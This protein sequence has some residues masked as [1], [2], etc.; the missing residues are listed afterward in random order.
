VERAPDPDE[1]LPSPA[2]APEPPPAPAVARVAAA[3]KGLG[4]RQGRSPG[5]R[6]P[7]SRSILG[8]FN[9]FLAGGL[10]LPIQ[11]LTLGLIGG[12]V[13]VHF[14]LPQLPDVKQGLT[15]VQLEQPLRVYSADGALMA[16][17]G[18]ERRL[19]VTYDKLPPLLIKAFL[20]TED[21]RFFE[22]GGIDAVGMGRALLSYASTGIKSQGGSTITMQVTRNFFLSPEKTFQRKLAEVLLALHVEKTL[23]KEE[24]LELYL[25]QIFFGHRAY[26]VAAAAALYY[27]KD[28]SQL[29]L[30]EMA[31]LAGLPKAPSAN[32]PVT[33]PERALERRNYILGRMLELGYIERPQ[34]EAAL[35]Q[36]DRAS[37]HGRE[38]ELEASNVAEMT[39]QEIL[40]HFGEAASQQGLKVTTTIES[41]LQVAA[42]ESVRK[43]LRQYERR[44]GYRGPEA[45]V[46]LTGA[47]EADMD[48]YLEGVAEI[49]ELPAGLVTKVGPQRAEVYLGGGRRIELGLAQMSWAREFRNANWRGPAPRR[50]ADVV[51]E[52]DLIRLRKDDQGA[53]ELS[54]IPGVT[55]AL[56]AMAP[57][58]GAVR[59]LVS[60]YSFNESKFNR[61]V[62]MRRQPGSS[63][64]PFIY[65]SALNE[66]WTPASLLKDQSIKL[67]LGGGEWWEPKNSDHKEMGPIRM[68]QALT[69]SRN[70]AS[71][72]LLNSVG[73]EDSQRF[74]RRFGFDGDAMPLGLSMALGTGE[75]SPVKMA[76][77]YS[78]FANGGY[79]VLPYFISRIEGADGQPIYVA[80][81]PH[82]CTDCWYRYGEAAPARTQGT[83]PPSGRQ[84]AAPAS[85]AEPGLAEQVIDPR[86][87]YQMTSMMR[88]V[89]ERGTATRAKRLGRTDI[90][91]KTGTTNDV[92]D[93]WFCGF[94]ADLVTV[95]W[96]GFD[97]FHKLGRGE[98]G[99]R[100]ALSMWTDFMETALKD[101]PVAQLDM[102]PGM[103]RVRI[104]GS[105]G[106]VTKSTGAM[107]EEVMEEYQ[108]MLLGPEP[109]YAE[110]IAKP[111]T[112]AKPKDTA[113]RSAPRVVEDLF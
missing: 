6:R 21:S 46:D 111:K 78:V 72:N 101:K 39:R 104:D 15:N 107:T 51:E 38:A 91:G 56:V 105:R 24:I 74:I 30:P 16:E 64:K 50:V 37:L 10:G 11:L 82:A 71:I 110:E 86:I 42:Q 60:G 49:P 77:G 5:P 55:G 8:W 48:A 54:A 58:D 14:T 98:E 90:V 34:Y 63:F 40:K 96:M 52:G 106:T 1:S 12:A 94:Q 32:N 45:Q 57:R 88:D 89:V 68:R 44:H 69:L 9:G 25:N 31:M 75:T 41:W 76:E 92:R 109:E 13:F 113:K 79:H 80:N 59:A 36:P 95:A 20:A 23:S 29:D 35:P 87:A 43:A 102:P 67:K 17:F 84:A 97:S 33:N 70:L 83:A 19:P 4:R 7:G 22:H 3:P 99:G 108:L 62:D 2:G 66:G 47:S 73:V 65:A 81:P 85:R 100:A 26:G 28:L 61:A 53:L 112:K 103:V 27:D 93:S 18:V